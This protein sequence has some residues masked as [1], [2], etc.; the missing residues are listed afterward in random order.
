MSS[1]RRE[2][3][4]VQLLERP[5]FLLAHDGHRR[6]VRRDHE[7]Q[8]RHDAG[9]HEVAA[10]EPRVEP[11]AHA[12]LDAC[13]R[14]SGARPASARCQLLRSSRHQV[15]ARTRAR[16]SSSSRR[17]RRRSTCTTAARPRRCARRKPAG[18]AERHPGA[19]PARA[20]SRSRSRCV[21]T[22]TIVKY[23]DASKRAIRSRLAAMRSAS[24]TTTG[25]F[26]T[27]VVAA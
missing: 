24:A 18:I 10:L 11:H 2:R 19:C 27:S 16:R 20:T 7:Q 13:R 23:G 17:C 12:G 25:T 21:T 15:R 8:Q 5:Q 22:P 3:R 9:N 1:H 6:Q 26:L 4:D 14:H